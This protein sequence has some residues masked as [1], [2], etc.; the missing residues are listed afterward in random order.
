MSAK[1]AFLPL[2]IA[3]SLALTGY[4]SETSGQ[5][6]EP[7]DTVEQSAVVDVTVA[8]AKALIDGEGSVVVL[9]VRTPEEFA[10]GHIE[11]ALNVDFRDENFPEELAKLDRDQRYIVHCR[12]GR[13]SSASMEVFEELGF[14]DIQHMYEGSNGWLEAEFPM[15]R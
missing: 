7:T 4:S 1:H 13:R 8:E 11:G 5:T 15:V 3:L 9:D 12:S 14:A 2:G 10:E 6:A